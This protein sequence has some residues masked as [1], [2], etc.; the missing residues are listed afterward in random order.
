MA[1]FRRRRFI[2]RRIRRRRYR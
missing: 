1:A 2:G